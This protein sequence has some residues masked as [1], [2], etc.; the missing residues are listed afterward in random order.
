MAVVLTGIIYLVLLFGDFGSGETIL[1]H[2]FNQLENPN[3]QQRRWCNKFKMMGWIGSS[4]LFGI[5]FFSPISIMD[6]EM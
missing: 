4:H 3:K 2:K 5:Y 6:D 1:S